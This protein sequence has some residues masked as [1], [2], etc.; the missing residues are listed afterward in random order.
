MSLSGGFSKLRSRSG[1]KVILSALQSNSNDIQY[2]NRG[3]TLHPGW[4]KVRRTNFLGAWRYS[5]PH[6]FRARIRASAPET[7]QNFS[8][9]DATIISFDVIRRV[10]D[11]C[12]ELYISFANDV[13]MNMFFF[14]WIDEWD[15]D[16]K[17]R[18]FE[19]QMDFCVDVA[20]NGM[21]VRYI[22]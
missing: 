1:I 20:M 6:L 3:G 18:W 5:A 8:T 7:D 11:C 21:W 12:T 15:S 2:R 16:H 17:Y 4:R 9:A 10:S 14:S 19:L 22:V 13:Q